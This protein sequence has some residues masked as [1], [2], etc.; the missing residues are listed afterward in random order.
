VA[1]AAALGATA[2]PERLRML[3]FALIE[4]SLGDAAR[5]SFEMLPQ[6]QRFFSESQRRSFTQ[7]EAKGEARALLLVL[8][9]RGFVVSDAKRE[10][11]LG[12]SDL[13]MLEGW[14]ARAISSA[15]IE[16]VFAD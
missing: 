7:G 13:G 1:A 11:I 6:G 9:R 4:S 16:D 3:C 5:K 2:L 12:C 8:E 15:N 14:L 10:Q